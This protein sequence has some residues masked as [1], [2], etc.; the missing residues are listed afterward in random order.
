LGHR[1]TVA[2]LILLGGGL[3]FKSVEGE[4]LLADPDG[5]QLGPDDA[6]EPVLVHAE[7]RGRAAKAHKPGQQRC[8]FQYG[9]V[10]MPGR[11]SSPL[12]YGISVGSIASAVAL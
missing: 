7:V 1:D 4:T 9:G 11:V 10:E 5:R 8:N 12:I 2:A 6:I 3:H